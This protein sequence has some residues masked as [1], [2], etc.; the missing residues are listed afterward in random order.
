MNHPEVDWVDRGGS[1]SDTDVAGAGLR[2]RDV[3]NLD[4]IGSAGGA[5]DSGT[6]S[7]CCL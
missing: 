1:D 6:E 3:E 7:G 2:Q 4:R 5:D